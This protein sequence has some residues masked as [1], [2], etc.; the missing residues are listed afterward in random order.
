L[1]G[2]GKIAWNCLEKANAAAKGS[3]CI[4]NVVFA[5]GLSFAQILPGGITSQF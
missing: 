4:D 1:C 3:S 5:A 2:L